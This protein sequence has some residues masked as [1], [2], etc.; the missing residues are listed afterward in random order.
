MLCGGG[1]RRGNG[2]PRGYDDS[3]L[4]DVK[5]QGKTIEPDNDPPQKVLFLL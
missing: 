4:A 1:E 5:L 3:D 2:S